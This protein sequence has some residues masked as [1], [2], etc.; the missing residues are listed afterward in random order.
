MGAATFI[1]PVRLPV[2]EDLWQNPW[3]MWAAKDLPAAQH[4]WRELQAVAMKTE[5]GGYYL[6]A[7]KEYLD[8]HGTDTVDGAALEAHARKAIVDLRPGFAE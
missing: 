2:D 6:R 3:V 1:T 8:E 7:A 4:F 5:G